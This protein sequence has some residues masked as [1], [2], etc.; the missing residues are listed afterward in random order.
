M[1]NKYIDVEAP[2]L[3]EQQLVDCSTEN[4]GCTS[5]LPSAAFEY[6]KQAGGLAYENSYFYESLQ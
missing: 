1:F 5:G 3:S 4:N 6:V 2:S